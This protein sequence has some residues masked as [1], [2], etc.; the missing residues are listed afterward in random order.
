MKDRNAEF[1]N[2]LTDS[3]EIRYDSFYL[4][5][6]G[7]LDLDEFKAG[8]IFPVRSLYGFV[9]SCLPYLDSD[10][11]EEEVIELMEMSG[12]CEADELITYL[13]ETAKYGSL[14]LKELD[15][16]YD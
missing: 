14:L 6:E 4:K 2:T 7:S 10:T 5:Y 11:V 9:E 3:W 8:R 13:W 1:Y 16:W 15:A 12:R